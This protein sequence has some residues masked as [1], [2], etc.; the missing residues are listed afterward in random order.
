MSMTVSLLHQEQ[1]KGKC[2]SFVPGRTL[3]FVFPSQRGQRM[4]PLI[5]VFTTCTLLLFCGAIG[6]DRT[7]TLLITN[8]PHLLLCY[9]GK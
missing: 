3:V 7:R 1:Y 6:R 4:K 9:D 5:F 2:T 8:Q